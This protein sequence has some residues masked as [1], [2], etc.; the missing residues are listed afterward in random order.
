MQ[1]PEVRVIQAQSEEVKPAD[2]TS[3][4]AEYL[5]YKYGFK[6]EPV[7][8]PVQQNPNSELTFDQLMEIERRREMD[9][10]KRNNQNQQQRRNNGLY[11]ETKWKDVELDDNNTFGIKIE[12][13]SDMK[14]PK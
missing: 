2:V 5:L 6:K 4:E 12:I 3:S 1:K 10:K 7:Q 13:V 11:T 14:I 8:Q 9:N